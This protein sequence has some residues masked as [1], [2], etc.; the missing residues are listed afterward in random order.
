MRSRFKRLAHATFNN[1]ERATARSEVP[2]PT[3]NRISR[4]IARS[5]WPYLFVLFQFPSTNPPYS[6]KG[7][8]DWALFLNASLFPLV[9]PFFRFCLV[10]PKRLRGRESLVGFLLCPFKR[11]RLHWLP[12]SRSANCNDFPYSSVNYGWQP[13]LLRLSYLMVNVLQ[14]LS[15]YLAWVCTLPSLLSILLYY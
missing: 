7:S 5:I 6:S 1:R 14:I 4:V 15:L 10:T 11:S 12:C 2:P 13:L 9:Y 8:P 3:R